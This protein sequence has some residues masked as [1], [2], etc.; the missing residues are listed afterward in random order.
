M[1]NWMITASSVVSAPKAA[2]SSQL[3]GQ[4]HKQVLSDHAAAAAGS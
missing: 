1:F 2:Q 4:A 3:G